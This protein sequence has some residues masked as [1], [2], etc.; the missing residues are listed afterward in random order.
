MNGLLCVCVCVSLQPCS[1][2]EVPGGKDEIGRE[3][4]KKE[5]KKKEGRER[6]EKGLRG[7]KRTREDK[8]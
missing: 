2:R 8:I 4:K 7:K 5:R 3:G 1:E 6:M